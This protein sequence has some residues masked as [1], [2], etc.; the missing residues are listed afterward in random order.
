MIQ[1]SITEKLL[2]ITESNLTG[3]PQNAVRLVAYPLA[4]A[5][6]ALLGLGSAFLSLLPLEGRTANFTQ[7]QDLTNFLKHLLPIRF[8]LEC[9]NP[10]APFPSSCKTKTHVQFIVRPTIDTT[11]SHKPWFYYSEEG[12]IGVRS[13][14]F[15]MN[16]A[17]DLR[18]SKNLFHKHVSTR[19]CYLLMAITAIVAR[20]LDL[21]VGVVAAVVAIALLGTNG[22]M[23]NL[24]VCGLSA[25]S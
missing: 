25:V 15:F 14:N 5:G 20:S 6:D 11:S 21:I 3:R 7:C 1:F 12:I 22:S 16:V 8:L 24:A 23:N 19:G 10:R 9:I 4:A 2:E 18:K 17:L 13:R